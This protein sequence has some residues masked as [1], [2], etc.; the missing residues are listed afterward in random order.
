M[1]RQP[2]YA[3]ASARQLGCNPEIA[4]EVSR[5]RKLGAELATLDRHARAATIRLPVPESS[6][7]SPRTLPA[8][9]SVV[10]GKLTVQFQTAEELFAK[11]YSLGE[12][13]VIGFERIRELV[14]NPLPRS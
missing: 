4:F 8:D 14:E 11:L 3:A 2:R 6:F 13:A 12:A 9:I 10:Q 7:I 1:P 5:R